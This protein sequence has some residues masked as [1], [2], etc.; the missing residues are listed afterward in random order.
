MDMAT[1]VPILDKTF[2][3][4]HSTNSLGEGGM[5]TIFLSSAMGTLQSKLGYLT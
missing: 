5:N 2:C 3:I 1:Q 4:L